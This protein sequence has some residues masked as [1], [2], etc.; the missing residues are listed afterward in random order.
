V[1]TYADPGLPGFTLTRLVGKDRYD[2]SVL[3]AEWAVSEGLAYTHLGVAVGDN[4]PD[5]LSAGPYLAQTGGLLILVQSSGVP[6]QAASL[7]IAQKESI[8]MVDFIGLAPA[9]VSQVKLLLS[10]S[11]APDGFTFSTVS[12]G[13]S[14]SNVLWLEQKL[15]ELTYRPGSIDGVFDS[16]TYQAVLAFQKW[17][18]LSRDGVVGAT[19]WTRLLVASTPVA[20]KMEPGTGSR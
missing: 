7:L 13:S 4:F 20:A 2:T 5:A 15:A 10:T 9:V 18:G 11:D 3:V 1:G 17:E 6:A 14:G 19:T 16:R 8:G 12:S